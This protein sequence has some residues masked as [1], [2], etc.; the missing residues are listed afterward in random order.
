M[1]RQPFKIAFWL[2]VVLSSG[3]AGSQGFDRFAMTEVL[4]I[5]SSSDG[6]NRDRSPQNSALSPPVRL[7]VFFPDHEF[8]NHQSLRKVEW[9]S[10]DREQLLQGLASLRDQELVTDIF[11]LMDSTVQAGNIDGIRQA[12]ARYGADA[13]LVIDAAGAIDRY[14]N[15]Y[16]WLYPTLIGAYLVPGTESAALVMVTGNLWAVHSDWHAPIRTAEGVSTIV[17][18]AVFVEDSAALQRAKE[19]A[20]QALSTNVVEQIRLWMQESPPPFSQ[21]R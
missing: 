20:I 4:H 11:V 13:V 9:L 3:C 15:R 1:I 14:N 21:L 2:T 18:S 19:H 6:G 8:P 12:G 5:T 7:A 16:A 10:A 17:G